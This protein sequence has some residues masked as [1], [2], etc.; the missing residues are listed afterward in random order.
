MLL[1]L[2]FSSCKYKQENKHTHDKVDTILIVYL[3]GAV[4]TVSSIDCKSMTNNNYY[5][6][7]IADTLR[8][9]H[10]D[11]Y[12]IRDFLRNQKIRKD[13]SSCDS[14]MYIKMDS[15]S[16]CIGDIYCA[17][18]LDGRALDVSLQ[19]IHLIKCKSG[20]Y[21]Y[22][23]KDQLLYDES[24]IKYGIPKDYKYQ[25]TAPNVKRKDFVKIIMIEKK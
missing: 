2:F 25:R 4:E 21:N 12:L 14:R 16:V 15:I 24:I 13:D 20:Y 11:F 5:K 3:T 9:S 23:S 6:R 8:I 22:F 17:C 10:N 7:M 18:N 19:T 1:I